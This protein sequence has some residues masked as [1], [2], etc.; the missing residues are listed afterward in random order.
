MRIN[1][2]SVVIPEAAIYAGE[3]HL[4]RKEIASPISY[5]GDVKLIYRTPKER[6]R[7]WLDLLMPWSQFGFGVGY[8]RELL[9]N[10]SYAVKGIYDDQLWMETAGNFLDLLESYRGKFIIEGIE[11]ILKTNGPVVFAANHMSVLETFILPLVI[12]PHKA[13]TFVVKESLTRGNLFG[14]IMRSRNPIALKRENPREDL[15]KVMEEGVEKLQNGLS[16]VIFPQST[17]DLVFR[18]KEFNSIATKLAKRANVPVI[19]IALKTDFWVPGGLIKDFGYLF[20]DRP[21]YIKFG[22]ALHPTVDP[23]KNQ[24]D[25]VGFIRSHL[26]EWGG[27]IED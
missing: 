1:K 18:P 25:I 7:S 9:R 17:R 13:N 3:F 22:E 12:T 16:L 26:E 20:R 27:Q 15:T 11:N 6:I 24:E 21:V 10:R 8:L 19:P 5:R 4:N 14:P 23:R 2:P